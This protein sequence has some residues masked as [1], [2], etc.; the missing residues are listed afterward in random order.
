MSGTANVDSSVFRDRDSIPFAPSGEAPSRA[1]R[2]QQIAA[3]HILVARA[4]MQPDMV[5]PPVQTD[6]VDETALGTSIKGPALPFEKRTHFAP[7][8]ASSKP[9]TPFQSAAP[10]LAA[11]SATPVT[12]SPSGGRTVVAQSLKRQSLPFRKSS[13]APASP[14]I[15]GWD[16]GRYGRLCIDLVKNPKDEDAVLAS[17]GIS[18]DQRRALDRY[19]EERMMTEPELRLEWKRCCDA[20]VDEL[21]RRGR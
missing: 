8:S 11:P 20:R 18:R 12:P 19:W 5:A 4:R 1:R 6:G 17:N 9:V 2:D 16:I 3:D 13:G 14:P 21:A 15:P 7:S 10:G